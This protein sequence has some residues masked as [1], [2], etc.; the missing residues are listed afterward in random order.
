MIFLT[1]L[2]LAIPSFWLALILIIVFAVNLQWLDSI[3]YVN[4][5]DDP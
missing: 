5:K 4:F 3:G 1:S 2:G